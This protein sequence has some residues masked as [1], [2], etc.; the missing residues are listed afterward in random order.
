M[1]KNT[2]LFVLCVVCILIYYRIEVYNTIYDTVLWILLKYKLSVDYNDQKYLH[3][4][5]FKIFKNIKNIDSETKFN[6]DKVNANI[7]SKNEYKI[8]NMINEKNLI[9]NIVNYQDSEKN[10]F[11]LLK[12]IL[13][14]VHVDNKKINIEDCVIIDVLFGTVQ[15]FPCVHTDVEWNMFNNSNG[16]QVWYLYENDDSVGNMFLIES[17]EVVSDTYL[18]FE[19]DNSVGMYEQCGYDFI[20]KYDNLDKLRAKVS[21]LNMK[22]GECLI[23]GRNLYHISDFR[24]SKHRFSLNFR[25]IIKDNDGGIPIDISKKCRYNDNLLGRIERKNIKYSNGKIYPN[26]FDLMYMI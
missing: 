21:Y 20:K 4:N 19:D 17:D 11:E 12:K 10:L 2:Y 16:F 15:L 22:S 5:F 18:K 3:E 14:N 9:T 6:I 1:N 26:M 13:P 24:Q 8:I 25:V 7:T 23:F